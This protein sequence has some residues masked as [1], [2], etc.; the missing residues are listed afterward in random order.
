MYICE[1]TEQR[2]PQMTI[3]DSVEATLIRIDLAL[4]DLT[5]LRLS[6]SQF[7]NFDKIETDSFGELIDKLLI[8]HI[9][10]WHLED[11]MSAEKDDMKLA[12]LRR[13]SESLFKEKRPML[14][15]ALDKAI[16][17]RIKNQSLDFGESLKLYK[18]W[19]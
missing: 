19:D 12:K 11:Q 16:V 7:P 9:R 6:H 4:E 14:V 8:V 1:P 13:K 15:A 5:D 3:D 2:N 18:G 17:S 10:Y